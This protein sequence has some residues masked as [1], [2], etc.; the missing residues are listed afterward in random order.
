MK[1][2]IQTDIETITFLRFF[3]ILYQIKQRLDQEKANN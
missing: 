1:K 2:T 3:R